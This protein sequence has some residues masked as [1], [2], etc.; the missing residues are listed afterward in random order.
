MENI[1][2]RD[3][4]GNDN[5]QIDENNGNVTINPNVSVKIG[6]FGLAEI[7]HPSSESFI[8]SKWGLKDSF[9]TTAP[10]VYD[11]M[12]F[13]GMKSDIWSLGCI[14][15]KMSAGMPLY[16]IPEKDEDSGF[17]SLCHG[18]MAMYVERHGLKKY[19]SKKVL[20]LI[21]NMLKIDENE[22]FTSLQILE[23]E[24]FVAYYKRYSPRIAQKSKTQKNALK[25]QSNKTHSFSY[26]YTSQ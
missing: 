11:G 3:D 9:E 18:K 15:F 26:Y 4:C 13:D 23:S 7:I 14:L 12:K 5:F 6:D 20:S 19:F 10:K 16:S 2:V 1:I 21:D 24:W 8:V 22:R 17:Y 25:Q